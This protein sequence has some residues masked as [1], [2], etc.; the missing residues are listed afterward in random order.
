MGAT[1]GLL[2]LGSMPL[3]SIG[4][5]QIDFE[6]TWPGHGWLLALAMACQVVGWI[7]ITH[8]LPRLPGAHTSFAVLIQPVLTI[9]WGIFILDETPS[10]QQ[11]LG[12]VMILVAI[13]AV[14]LYGSATTESQS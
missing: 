6:I 9:I 13:I 4:V 14:T 1:I 5:E 2:V 11:S 12:M 8:A 10:F 3:G 7:A